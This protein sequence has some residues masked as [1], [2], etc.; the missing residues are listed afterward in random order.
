MEQN[1]SFVFYRSFYEA[2]KNL[3]SETRLQVYDAIN[4]YAL[5][6]EEPEIN[7][8]AAS[9]MA[10]IKPQI[11]ANQERRINGSKGGRP[12]KK[13]E[14][15]PMVIKKSETK[16]PTVMKKDE[17]KKPNA[18]VNANA[19]ANVNANKIYNLGEFQN[20]KLTEE[21]INKLNETYGSIKTEAYIKYLDEYIEMKGYKAKN[22]YLAIKKWVVDAVAE[23]EARKAKIEKNKT[24]VEKQDI[25][26][27]YSADKNPKLDSQ[28]LNELLAKRKPS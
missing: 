7:N 12:K 23:E 26:P 18:N 4:E 11:D 13:E 14:E 1:N 21:Q 10:L 16:K 5:N 9:L 22:H 27:T 19:N 6:G 17:N 20:I 2:I 24:I 15:K 25:I 28:R 3:D 8:I